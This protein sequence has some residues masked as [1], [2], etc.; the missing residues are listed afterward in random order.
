M[1]PQTRTA[2]TK[3]SIRNRKRA[4]SL[5][6]PSFPT[7][8]NSFRFFRRFQNLL[9]T[10]RKREKREIYEFRLPNTVECRL[11]RAKRAEE[12]FGAQ[13]KTFSEHKLKELG[14]ILDCDCDRAK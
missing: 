4:K 10:D 5:E 2:L 11:L 7:H 3:N 6:L 8:G 9:S 13:K 14:I 1:P 12:N